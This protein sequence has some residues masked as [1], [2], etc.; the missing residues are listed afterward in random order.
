M[1]EFGDMF[2]DIVHTEFLLGLLY[3]LMFVGLIRYHLRLKL[4]HVAK[5]QTDNQPFNERPFCILSK[6]FY[7]LMDRDISPFLP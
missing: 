3:M 2:N 4:G 6:L 7:L 5:C 1:Y